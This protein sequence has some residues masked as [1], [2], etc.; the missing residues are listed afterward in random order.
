MSRK[1][2]QV[3]SWAPAFRKLFDVY[4]DF[5]LSRKAMGCRERT[6][7]WYSETLQWIL[8][9]MIQNGV[10]EPLDIQS[11][12]I[13]AYLASMQERDLS[14]YYIHNHARTIRTFLRFLY[15][16]KYISDLPKFQMPSVVSKQLLYLTAPDVQKLIDACTNRRDKALILLMVD[17]GARRSEVCKLNWEDVDVASGL[18]HIMEG[19]GGK[20]RSVVVGVETRRALLAYRRELEPL[21]SS[22]M[23][24]TEDRHRFQIM[25]F[26]S[27]FDRL[28]RRA[29]VKVTPHALRRTFATMSLRAGMNPLH[30]QA[31]MGHTT[32]EMTRK[33]ISMIDDDL[34]VAHKE[35]GPIDNIL[36]KGRK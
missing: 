7:Q 30:L 4:T 20:T 34:I 19:K 27:V 21:P 24:Q 18:V 28:G 32:M 9:W 8:E 16:E 10:S 2:E 23:F 14:D 17:T 33:Y 3:P 26:R 11:R 35:Y 29:G 13:R 5:L 15:N 12:H 6:M 22:P 1:S 25:G 31:L 36:H